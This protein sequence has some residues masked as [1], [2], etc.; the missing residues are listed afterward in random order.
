MQAFAATDRAA[1]RVL[2]AL[3]TDIT[4]AGIAL[5]GLSNSI[6][7][8]GQPRHEAQKRVSATLGVIE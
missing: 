4:S 1:A 6:G 3:G 2:R 8:Y 7:V 5:I